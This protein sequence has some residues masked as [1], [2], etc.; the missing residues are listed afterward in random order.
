[1]PTEHGSPVAVTSVYIRTGV[2]QGLRDVEPV[3]EDRKVKGRIASAVPLVRV[4]A[5]RDKTFHSLKIALVGGL[6]QRW[7]V[8][9]PTEATPKSQ[10]SEEP[11]E[12][13]KEATGER[14]EKSRTVRHGHGFD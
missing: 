13:K 5:L 11:E 6:V 1:M 3:C 12:A 10:K 2:D 8:Q 9:L 14:F 7:R 4:G